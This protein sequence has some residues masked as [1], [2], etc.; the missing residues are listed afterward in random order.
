M[1]AP[2]HPR[3][4]ALASRRSLLTGAAALAAG[5]ALPGLLPLPAHAED[6]A[7]YPARPVRLLVG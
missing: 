2:L 1:T 7:A 6:A 5:A 4:R 3:A